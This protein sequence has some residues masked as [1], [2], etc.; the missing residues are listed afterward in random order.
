[1]MRAMYSAISGLRSHQ[2]M[3]DVAANDLANVNTLGYKS[4]R[5]TFAD[6]LSQSMERGATAAGASGGGSNAAQIGLG[7]R[8]SSIDVLMGGGA[9]QSTG[10]QLD[11]AIAG[12]GWFR[13]T[14]QL[15]GPIMYQRAGNFSLNS[16]GDLV[17]QEGYIVIGRGYTAGPPP[18]PGATDQVINIPADATN[19]SVG[20]DGLV[21][22]HDGAGVRQYAGYVTVAQFSNENGLIRQGGSR[23]NTSPSSGNEEVGTPSVGSYGTLIAGTVEMSNVDMASQFTNLITAQRGFQA[24]SR[25]IS[26]AD[27]MLSELVRIAR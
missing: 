6:S 17:T 2:M 19:V 12:D 18:V 27:E 5:V 21:S 15:G 3:M 14:N 9:L 7:V 10:N 8:L 25:V 4:S 11:M 16:N 22:Y 13:V 24:S 26:T 23:W 20:Q 1:M